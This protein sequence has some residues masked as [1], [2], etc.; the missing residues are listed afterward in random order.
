LRGRSCLRR[1]GLDRPR[2][3]GNRSSSLRDWNLGLEGSLDGARLL[4]LPWTNLECVGVLPSLE[5]D[6]LRNGAGCGTALLVEWAEDKECVGIRGLRSS[7]LWNGRGGG[8]DGSWTESRSGGGGGRRRDCEC[9]WAGRCSH[10]TRVSMDSNFI[11]DSGWEG[12]RGARGKC[13][14][15]AGR[16]GRGGARRKCRRW[17]GRKGGSCGRA[18]AKGSYRTRCN[19]DWCWRRCSGGE[20]SS[21][22]NVEGLKLQLEGSC[23]DDLSWAARGGSRGWGLGGSWAPGSGG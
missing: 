8:G 18:R 4:R 12:G 3:L 17:T 16:K 1:L 5:W 19:L 9:Y 2:S 10:G 7:L 13:R 14:R 22:R 6:G 23:R 11:M 21:S 20:G 15:W